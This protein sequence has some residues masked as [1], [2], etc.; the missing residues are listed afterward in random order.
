MGAEV[1]IDTKVFIYHLCRSDPRE[2]GAAEKIVRGALTTGNAW[3]S[4]E[5]LQECLNAVLP[6]AEVALSVEAG[7]PYLDA[8]LAPLM[9]V[10]TASRCSTGHWICRR[11]GV[12]AS[13]TR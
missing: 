10:T 12:S 6:K 5:A 9:Q 13:T 3:I 8:V 4:S 11:V 1:F 2:H 7:P